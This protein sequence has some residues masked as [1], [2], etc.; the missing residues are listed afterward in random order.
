M[1]EGPQTDE[2]R[3]PDVIETRELVVVLFGAERGEEMEG[4]A[5]EEKQLGRKDEDEE[6]GKVEDSSR[7][8]P[9]E[10][11]VYR[12]AREE[13]HRDEV[14][15]HVERLCI[16]SLCVNFRAVPQKKKKK[17]KKGDRCGCGRR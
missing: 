11:G 1:I 15:P 5:A 3:D 14:R 9:R 2:E 12:H 16:G 7:A 8:E 10:I 13:E 17:K 4:G 6:N